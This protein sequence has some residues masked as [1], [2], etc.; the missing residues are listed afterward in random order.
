MIV[1]STPVN[2]VVAQTGVKGDKGDRGESVSVFTLSL[3]N[4]DL[5]A[6]KKVVSHDLNRDIADVTI[7]NNLNQLVNA[8]DVKIVSLT[9][10][11]VDLSSYSPIV[12]TWKLLIQ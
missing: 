12:G 2:I 9:S 11:E 3:T 10:V 8:D 7:R 4:E 5:T 1:V 6:G